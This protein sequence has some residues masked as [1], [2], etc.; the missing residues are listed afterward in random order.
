MTKLKFLSAALIAA[1]MLAT[2]AM[3]R[4]SHISSRHLK[5]ATPAAVNSMALMRVPVMRAGEPSQ[6][7]L[8]KDMK[9]NPDHSKPVWE[10]NTNGQ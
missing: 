8:D 2:P 6:A 5:G 10:V 4:E 3:A 1:A 9:E 7:E